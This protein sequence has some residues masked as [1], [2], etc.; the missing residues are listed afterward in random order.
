MFE[1]P[2]LAP[3]DVD[4][5]IRQHLIGD[6]FPLVFDLQRSRGSWIVDARDGEEYLDFYT[7]F[8][9]LPLGF[10]HRVFEREENRRRLLEAALTKPANSDAH[11]CELARFTT[12][13][14]EHALP[15]GF[16][17]LFFVEGGALAVENAIKAAF[18]WKVR[19]NVEA[20]NDVN[21]GGELG[22]KILHFREAFHG[23]SGYT[24][25]LTNT[26]PIKTAHFPKFHWPRVR[27]PKL[28]FPVDDAE[29]ARVEIEEKATLDEITT[30]F[31]QHRNDVA[32]IIIEPIQGEG[33]D[34]H[35]RPEFLRSLRRLADDFEALLIFDEVQTGFGMT[36]TM[37]AFEQFGVTPDII[38][39]GK[40]SQVC[41]IAAGPKLDEVKDNVFHVSSRINS[42]WG[43]GLVDMVRCEMILEAMEEE[44]LVDNAARVGAD[45]LAGLGTLAEEHPDIVSNVRGRGLFCA[46]DCP[47]ADVRDRL[48]QSCF[49]QRV[50]ALSCGDRSV[51]VRPPLTLSS[52]EAAEGVKRIGKAL[53]S[54]VSN[55]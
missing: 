36:G 15:D 39:F 45:L 55:V 53:V 49:G 50:L 22:T 7:F 32:A 1:P 23:R 9:S 17:H 12:T 8:A 41:G 37:W 10:R 47:D 31:T 6:G 20:G 40:K 4:H 5:V 26:L 43:G 42:T 19:L 48:L 11:T 33:G 38:A 21:G 3:S 28:R 30:A 25:S 34:N 27:N 2:H 29:I 52:E 18:D 54:V 44:S 13:F 46:F 24:L 14:A 51:R 16:R 35:F